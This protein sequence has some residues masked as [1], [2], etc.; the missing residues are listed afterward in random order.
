MKTVLGG[1]VF[2]GN[3]LVKTFEQDFKSEYKLNITEINNPSEKGRLKEYFLDGIRIQ[4]RDVAINDLKLSVEHDFPF[5]KLHFE[6]EGS[7]NYQPENTDEAAL[8]IPN[9][10]YNMF[11]IPKVKGIL[12]YDTRYR[13]TLEIIFTEAYIKKIIGIN[14]KETLKSF[15]NAI[16]H[17]TPFVLWKNSKPISS[18]LLTKIEEIITCDY[19][20]S[21]KKAYLEAK[22]N[23]LIIELL[24]K[25]NDKNYQ[26]ENTLL[27]KVSYDRMLKV[28]SYIQKNL[29][30]KITINLL[31]EIIGVNTTTL[32]Q[33][34]KIVF[35]T[36]IF[37]YMTKL[38]MEKS[39][40]L[41]VDKKYS[42]AQ[43]SAEVGYQNPQHF[44]TA[45][46][47]L[48]GYTPKELK[49]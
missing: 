37:K 16:D 11:Y 15:G 5:F 35:A 39:K 27:D 43:A 34:F 31:S 46:K 38:R 12:N 22:V 26:I 24:A 1:S 28:A 8:Y 21:L 32:K 14:F 25:T 20:E 19:P 36:T 42:I 45:F 48:Y 49:Q 18:S 10:H 13:K 9:G 17:K 7:S 40:I 41:I 4:I 6:I 30:K 23:E 29:N 2:K 33:D 44:T 3:V 47:K